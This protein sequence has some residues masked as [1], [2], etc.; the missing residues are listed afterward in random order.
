[1]KFTEDL[2]K[3]QLGKGNYSCYCHGGGKSWE[4]SRNAYWR[5]NGEE[6][7]SKHLPSE[8]MKLKKDYDWIKVDDSNLSDASSSSDSSDSSESSESSDSGE[9][10]F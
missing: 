4:C 7:C 10:D 1:M 5:F 3:N 2:K 6:Y 9:E 8:G